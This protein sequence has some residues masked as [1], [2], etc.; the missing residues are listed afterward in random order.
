MTRIAAY[1]IS[2][3]ASGAPVS[4]TKR[5]ERLLHAQSAWALLSIGT[6]SMVGSIEPLVDEIAALFQSTLGAA[7]VPSNAMTDFIRR[8]EGEVKVGDRFRCSL[9]LEILCRVDDVLRVWRVGS[10]GVCV[11]PTSKMRF[12]GTDQRHLAM[13]E[14][15]QWPEPTV[16]FQETEILENMI[17]PCIVGASAT[18]ESFEVRLQEDEVVVGFNQSSFPFHPVPLRN[19]ITFDDLWSA[20][21]GYRHG[22]V[23]GALLLTPQ[24]ELVDHLPSGI[25]ARRLDPH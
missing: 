5:A 4:L 16:Q 12:M 23:G 9:Y 22:F 14:R 25:T 19:P 2:I 6:T 15:G 24:P 10:N 18:Y 1:E 11:G 13:R 21:A 7:L 17:S 20:E 3:P 8:L